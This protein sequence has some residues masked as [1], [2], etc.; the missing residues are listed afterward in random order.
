MSCKTIES[1]FLPGDTTVREVHLE[2]EDLVP[3]VI[4]GLIAAVP[5]FTESLVQTVVINWK[6]FLLLLF[7][8][9][10]FKL[11][12]LLERRRYERAGLK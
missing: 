3:I 6:S 5:L 2:M 10:I 11:P 1:F 8:Y 9:L 7:A 12:D 4:Q